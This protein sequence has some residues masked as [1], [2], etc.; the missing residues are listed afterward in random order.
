[1]QLH[2]L[3][4]TLSIHEYSLTANDHLASSDPTAKVQRI[5][6]LW[7]CLETVKAWF[8]TFFSL[9]AFPLS[10]YLHL[11]MAIFSQLAR[12]LVTL[13]SLSTFAAVGVPWDR[14]RVAQEL[15]LGA[16]IKLIADR[17]ELVLPA[18]GIEQGSR[19]SLRNCNNGQIPEDPWSNTKKKV[20]DIGKWWE[21]KVAAM[22]AA[23]LD[24]RNG[25]SVDSSISQ[26]A[27]QP[28]Q[29]DVDNM[30][31][32]GPVDMEMVNDNWLRDLMGGGYDFNLAQH[33]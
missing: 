9:E 18:A 24:K 23:D 1:M 20:S 11:S 12:C 17:W 8:N 25:V 32:Y 22:Y 4:T 5:E 7:V 29:Q 27:E 19:Q 16:I 26:S 21:A 33:F 6:G 28:E 30:F 10:C 13:Y 3:N 14:Q 2:I 31:E 15:N